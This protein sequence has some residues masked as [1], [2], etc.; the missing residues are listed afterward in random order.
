MSVILSI[1]KNAAGTLPMNDA[2]QGSG[3]G[4]DFGQIVVGQYA[5]L[6]NQIANTGAAQIFLSHDGDDPITS[7]KVYLA[8]YT[9]TGFT[10][11]GTDNAADNYTDILAAGNA[12]SILAESKNNINGTAGGIWADFRWDVNTTN[13]FDIA[14]FPAFVK[15]FGKGGNGQDEATAYTAL[16]ESMFFYDGVSSNTAAGATDG[17]IGPAADTSLGNRCRILSRVYLPSSF[18]DGGYYQSALVFRFAFTA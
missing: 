10:Y 5:P 4:L 11:G 8:V 17:I 7:L 16:K 3:T 9:V 18:A 2:L 12:S 14:N 1:S 15:I 6:V 13:Q